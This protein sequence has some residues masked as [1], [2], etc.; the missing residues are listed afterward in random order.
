MQLGG[1]A[2]ATAFFKQHACDTTEVQQKYRSRAASLYKTKLA[3]M[4]SGQDE[5]EESKS[6][7]GKSS[8]DES[9]AFEELDTIR[10]GPKSS[11]SI[12]DKSSSRLSPESKP[13]KK[14]VK[15]PEKPSNVIETY[16]SWRNDR[17]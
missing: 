3:Q 11:E 12:V 8:E 2:N 16:S 6:K 10:V 9:D 7:S 5:D 17:G 1:N 14:E 13:R 15:K 4:V